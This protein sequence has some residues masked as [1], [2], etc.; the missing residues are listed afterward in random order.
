[1]EKIEIKGHSKYFFI[2]SFVILVLISLVIIW[3]FFT[4][5]LGSMI[6]TYIFYP[7]YSRL[8]L[9]TKNKNLSAFFMSVFILL[10]LIFPA[11]I[12][13]NTLIRESAGLF[14][15]IRNVNLGVEEFTNTFLFKYLSENVDLTSYIK[16][17][18]NTFSIEIL[19]RTDNFIFA[20]PSKILNFFVM[21]FVMFFLFKD[22]RHMVEKIKDELPLREKY[23]QDLSKKFS[24][25]IYATVYGVLGAAFLQG[26]FAL[27]G[28]FIFGA[29]SPLFLAFLTFI[30][31]LLPFVGSALIWLPVSIVKL[32]SGDNFNGIG[33]IIYGILVISSIDNVIKPMIMGKKS[34]MHPALALLGILGG[35]QVF[36]IIGIVIGPLSMAILVVFF[37]FYLIEK[38]EAQIFIK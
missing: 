18:L 11:I 14:Y 27:I 35:L 30:S 1:M 17:A 20:L 22:G 4:T 5:I 24:D 38:K 33:L 15:L 28:F 2:A 10:L 13:A 9:L 29:N 31:A 21:F 12:L 3:P 6:I 37:D 8:L 19:Q 32:V 16:S 7:L 34:K 36:G 23:K 25:T 26:I